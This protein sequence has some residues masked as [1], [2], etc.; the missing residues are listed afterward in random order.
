MQIFD[1]FNSKNR[2]IEKNAV[3]PHSFRQFSTLFPMQN[4]KRTSSTRAKII[5]LPIWQDI[6]T[7]TST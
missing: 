7:A 6:L 1:S 5:T 3:F 4:M 2:L